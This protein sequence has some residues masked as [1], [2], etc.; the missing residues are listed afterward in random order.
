MRFVC[1]YALALRTQHM[2][3]GSNILAVLVLVR[4]TWEDERPSIQSH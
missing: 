1:P 3:R 4:H 2:R